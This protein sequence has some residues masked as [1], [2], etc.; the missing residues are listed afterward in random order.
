MFKGVRIGKCL[1]IDP[2]K[3]TSITKCDKTKTLILSVHG[4]VHTE[5]AENVTF[6]KGHTVLEFA[7][8]TRAYRDCIKLFSNTYE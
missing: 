3:I 5:E 7:L 1:T 6:V 4:L 8:G 2:N